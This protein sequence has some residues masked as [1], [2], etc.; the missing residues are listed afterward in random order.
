MTILVGELK[1]ICMFMRMDEA[2]LGPNLRVRGIVERFAQ[3]DSER[4][5]CLFVLIGAVR[6]LETVVEID[7]FKIIL[8]EDYYSSQGVPHLVF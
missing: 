6:F 3:V 7:H 4:V 8:I 5:H 2:V 1:N